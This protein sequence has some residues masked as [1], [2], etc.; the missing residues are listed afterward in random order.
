[1]RTVTSMGVGRGRV[2]WRVNGELTVH[3]DAGVAFASA[4]ARG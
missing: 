1:M 3:P 4:G 2:G